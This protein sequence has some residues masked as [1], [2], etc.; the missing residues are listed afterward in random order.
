M[1]S[2]ACWAVLMLVLPARPAA[3]DNERRSVMT[4]EMAIELTSPV[5]AEGEEI[6]GRYTCD[7][8]N[9]SPPL[10]WSG[11]PPG[12]HSLALICDDP[13]APV[14]TW[15]HWVLFNLPPG[16]DALPEAIPA[17]AVLVNGTRQGR[18]DF[19]RYGYGGPCPPRGSH[20]YY[21]KLYALDCQLQL[22][23][24]AGKTEL[25]QAMQGHI[26]AEGSLMGRYR[27]H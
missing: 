20:R 9:I 19:R 21:F 4:S 18:N 23:A 22:P 14:G 7:G 16:L 1:I 2:K 5:F 24:A 26:L 6:P 3:A 11:A 12:T 27:R 15:V 17:E 13:D 10:A 8:E 25:L